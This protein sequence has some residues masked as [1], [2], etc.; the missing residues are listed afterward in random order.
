MVTE[1]ALGHEDLVALMSVVGMFLVRLSQART[2]FDVNTA[3]GVTEEELGDL[4]ASWASEGQ[5]RDPVS[6]P[7]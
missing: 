7:L 4:M 1:G 3:A 2:M 6:K 5:G